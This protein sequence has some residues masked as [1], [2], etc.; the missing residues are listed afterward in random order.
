MHEG[1]IRVPLGLPHRLYYDQFDFMSQLGLVESGAGA[2]AGAV[3]QPRAGTDSEP[4]HL[5]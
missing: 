4:K 5:C 2:S 3:P 1:D